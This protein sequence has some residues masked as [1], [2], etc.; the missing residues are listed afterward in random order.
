MMHNESITEQLH[1]LKIGKYSSKELTENYLYRIK[2]LKDLNCYISVL[3]ESALRAA[4]DADQARA[5]GKAGL[6]SGIPIAHKDIFCTKDISTTA[7]SKMLHN[8]IAPFDATVVAKIAAAGAVTIGKTNMDEFAMGS[9]NETS[10][11]GPVKNP[12]DTSRVPGGSSGGSAA[13]VAAGLCSAA[14]GTDTGGSIR[15]PAAHCGIT[16]LKPTYGRVSRWGMIAFASSLD[17]AG[18]MTRTAEDAALMLALMA[19]NDPKDSTCMADDVPTYLE[20]LNSSL[21]GAC[22]GICED[23]FTDG[24]EAKSEQVIQE[25]IKIFEHLGAKIKSIKLPHIRYS[26]PAY[27]VIAPAEASTNLSR[28][29]GVRFGHRC[30]DP[31]NLNDL[32]K[33][34]RSEGFG[35][36]VKRR[37]MVGAFTLST[38]YYDAYYRQA[39]QIRRLIKNDFQQ[40]FKEVDFLIGPTAPQTAF[41]L[42]EKTDSQ[43]E[44]YL[45][46]IYTIAGNLAGLPAMS[47]PVGFSSKLPVGLQLIANHS[48]EGTILSAAHQY[49][50]R[51]DWHKCVPVLAINEVQT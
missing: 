45:Q 20:Y 32:F 36:E 15:Q 25:A 43:I 42:G 49:Q 40:A 30:K 50:Q 27:Y 7:G 38:G 1:A 6:L 34:S 21:D 28:Y 14:T 13:A 39:Q 37:I 29:D 33:R 18:P 3:E 4:T 22:I 41:Q 8:Y 48:Q 24:L 26:V 51:T 44:M 35:D 47:I 12:W 31:E 2:K 10:Y 23:F 19:G 5:K 9:S 16:G 46:D 17:Q 11:F